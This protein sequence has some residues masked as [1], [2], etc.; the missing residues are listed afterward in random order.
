ESPPCG[1]HRRRPADSAPTRQFCESACVPVDGGTLNETMVALLPA[2]GDARLGRG[3]TAA[4][5]NGGS[6]EARTRLSSD[7]GT[8]SRS[9]S[10]DGGIEIEWTLSESGVALPA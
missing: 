3:G 8:R 6:P 1:V 9:G 2:G 4:D 10:G 5:H 7:D